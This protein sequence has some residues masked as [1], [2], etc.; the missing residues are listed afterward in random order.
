VSSSSFL[1]VVPLTAEGL[2]CFNIDIQIDYTSHLYI[3][4]SYVSLRSI[5]LILLFLMKN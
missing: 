1:L 5:T 2:V 3:F 4:S